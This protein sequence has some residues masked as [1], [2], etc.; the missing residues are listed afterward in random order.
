[1]LFI[2]ELLLESCYILCTRSCIIYSILLFLFPNGDEN[3]EN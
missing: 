1:M 3:D 2:E